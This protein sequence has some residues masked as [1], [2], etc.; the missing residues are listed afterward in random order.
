MGILMLEVRACLRQLREANPTTLPVCLVIIAFCAFV[1]AAAYTLKVLAVSIG[2]IAVISACISFIIGT[3]S[4][5]KENVIRILADDRND[6]LAVFPVNIRMLLYFKTL[7][8]SLES[9]LTMV[10]FIVYFALVLVLVGFDPF[11]VIKTLLISTVLFLTGNNLK[12]IP[13]LLFKGSGFSLSKSFAKVAV[14][15][16]A[17]AAAYIFFI[18]MMHDTALE[19]P[20]SINGK[21]FINIL[22]TEAF[23]VM[24]IF[25]FIITEYGKALAVGK[26]YIDRRKKQSTFTD[27]PRIKRVLLKG[28]SF[29]GAK[30]ISSTI[31][32][33]RVRGQ[34]LERY[35][36][37]LASVFFTLFALDKLLFDF[38]GSGNR[39]ILMF[40]LISAT[41]SLNNA[42][43][44]VSC[45]GYDKK[46]IIHYIMSGYPIGNLLLLKARAMTKWMW[47]LGLP[48]IAIIQYFVRSTSLELLSLLI[49]FYSFMASS[50]VSSVFFRG[51]KTSYINDLNIPNKIYMTAGLVFHVFI[52]YMLMMLYVIFMII[53]DLKMGL[54]IVASLFALINWGSIIIFTRLLKK[55]LRGFYGEYSQAV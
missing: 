15:S 11:S 44:T 28:S 39:I 21:F 22:A 29:V 17:S 43:Y 10:A 35:L 13:S 36:A 38:P 46:M 37:L 53:L 49:I 47:L 14:V 52:T 55:D 2:T 20:F 30:D 50:A 24:I 7:K 27:S 51:Y 42:F 23:S 3:I 32:N 19:I 34:F 48:V 9:T 18:S 33:E 54:V 4:W 12:A 26:Y 41:M 5:N 6:A 40:I 31:N 8:C 45:I 1:L 16:G 25:L